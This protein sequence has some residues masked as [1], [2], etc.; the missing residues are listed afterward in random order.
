VS[1][2]SDAEHF[3]QAPDWTWYILFYFF[4]AGISGGSYAV[5]AMLRLFGRSEDE[6]LMRLAYYAAFVALLP[7]PVL[8]VV[9]L[10][11][12]VRFWHMLVNTT[13]GHVGP[14]FKYWSP[15]S[16]GAWALLIFGVFATASFFETLGRDGRRVPLAR[17]AARVLGGWF[18]ML[19]AVIGGLFGLFVAGYT[20]V[21]LSVSNQP[22]WSDTW[23]L[24]GLFLV[25]GLSAS[26]AL[27]TWLTRFRSLARYSTAFLV[28]GEQW[29]QIL[30]LALIAVFAVTVFQAGTGWTAFGLPWLALW[31]FVLVSLVPG[32]GG[33]GMPHAA[34][35]GAPSGDSGSRGGAAAAAGPS[36]AVVGPWLVLLG[37]LAL[38]AVII[39]SAQ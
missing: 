37:V 19:A 18:G 39:F 27:L 33:F 24:G 22:V 34:V 35:V 12:P 4:F 25:S 20:G 31:G 30:E 7:C 14:S 32:I 13:P 29:F 10:G 6:P 5:A 38:R 21:L 15:M 23:A 3:V 11:Q 28:R 17:L 8:L 1:L 26:V 2:L 9:D 36:L 16:V